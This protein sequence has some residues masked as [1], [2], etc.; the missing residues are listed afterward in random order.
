MISNSNSSANLIFFDEIN[1]LPDIEGCW[2]NKLD[3]KS[4]FDYKE[5][6]IV[7]NQLTGF[8]DLNYIFNSY[9]SNIL[10]TNKF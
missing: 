4:L 10:Q 7:N 2:W 3:L 5:D 9:L 8:I 1:D 6:I